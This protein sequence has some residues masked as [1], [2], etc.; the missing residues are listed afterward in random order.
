MVIIIFFFW[1]DRKT[2]KTVIRPNC[3]NKVVVSANCPND[4]L[5]LLFSGKNVQTVNITS[6]ANPTK[7][8]VFTKIVLTPLISKA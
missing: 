5:Y 2:G 8:H 3:P 4:K 6:S 7:L 1:K